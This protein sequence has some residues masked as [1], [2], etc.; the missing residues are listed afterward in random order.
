M[1]RTLSSWSWRDSILPTNMPLIFC[2]RQLGEVAICFTLHSFTWCLIQYCKSY[3]TII[4]VNNGQFYRCPYVALLPVP[5]RVVLPWYSQI[6]PLYFPDTSLV[7]HDTSMVLPWYSPDTSLV[8]PWYFPDTSMILPW[9]F[10]GTSMILPWY[11]P[12]TSLILPW[13]FMILP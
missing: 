2:S 4:N 13:Y 3:F 5:S 11:F 8:I 6:L 7:H 1:R 12:G 9:Y 10:P